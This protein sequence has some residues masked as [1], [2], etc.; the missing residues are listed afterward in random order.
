ME[1]YVVIKKGE[2]DK[3]CLDIPHEFLDK[4]LKITVIPVGRGKDVREKIKSLFSRHPTI[5]PFKAIKDPVQ[6]Q[7]EHRS[8]W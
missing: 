7:K 6:W 2:S 5:K 8:E 4:E 3:H 1:A